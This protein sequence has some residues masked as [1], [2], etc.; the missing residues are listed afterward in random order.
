[1][2]EQI[3]TTPLYLDHGWVF[4]QLFLVFSSGSSFEAGCD[5]SS[6]PIVWVSTSTSWLDSV[7]PA[8]SWWI[9]TTMQV[10]LSA[11]PRVKAVSVSFRA[12]ATGSSSV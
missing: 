5:S 4:D 1:M 6:L 8:S 9:L 7:G 2:N 3:T 11:L 12:A 10:M